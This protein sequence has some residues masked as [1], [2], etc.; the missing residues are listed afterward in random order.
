MSFETA[1]KFIDDLLDDKYSDYISVETSP[2]IIVEFIGG[3]PLLEIDLIDQICDYFVAEL[4]RRQHPWATRYCFSMCSNG[5]LYFDP[6]V[7]KF[8]RKHLNHLS[9]SISID[10]NKELH[11]ACRVFADG[12][13]SYDIAM[14][15][16]RH[17]RD[18]LGGDIGSKM[19]LCPENVQYCYDA[20][21]SLLENGYEEIFLNC[22]YEEGWTLEHAKILYEQLKKLGQYIIDNDLFDKVYL[23]IFVE[24]FFRPKRAEENDNWCGGLGSMISVDYKGDIYPCIRYM[25]SSLGPDIEPLMIGNVD[26]GVMTTCKER[27]CVECMRAV[28]RRSQS[29][30]ECWNCPIAEGCSWCSAYNYQVYGTVDKRATFI[31]PMHKAR[32]LANAWFWNT[33]F[34]KNGENKRFKMYIPEEWALEIIDKEEY[35]ELK[36]LEGI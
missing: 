14:E 9:F 35:E 19:T 16:V 15:G 27:D 34:R 17:Y 13:G 36:K 26:H 32:A 5:V 7:Q 23:S 4:I 21:V 12:S 3:E 2:G 24:H 20:T 22:V 29:T 1:K 33:G 8:L 6:R 18:V 11:D 28:T 10:G 25:E 30:D 31:C